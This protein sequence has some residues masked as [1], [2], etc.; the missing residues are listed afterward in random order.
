MMTLLSSSV[1]EPWSSVRARWLKAAGVADPAKLNVASDLI[2]QSILD[3]V[4]RGNVLP[5]KWREVPIVVGDVTAWISVSRDA[6]RVGVPGDSVRVSVTALTA[7]HVADM[8]GVLLATPKIDDAAWAAADVRLEPVFVQDSQQRARFD[9]AAM[10][11]HSTTIDHRMATAGAGEGDLVRGVGKGWDMSKLIGPGNAVNYGF[12]T[13]KPTGAGGRAPWPAA[14]KLGARVW[15]PPGNKH[16]RKHADYSQTLTLVERA[17]RIEGPS[18][19]SAADVVAL[20]SDASTAA[21]VSHEGPV[22]MRDPWIEPCAPLDAG[23]GC[24]DVGTGGPPPVLPTG[25]GGGL[26]A[27]LRRVLPIGVAG[28]VVG[29]A[30][31]WDAGLWP[32]LR[33]HT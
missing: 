17:A 14:T 26:G 1:F 12:P 5:I 13:S 32:F 11:I 21:L 22:P 20:A 18:G 8:L 23:G 15:Q 7:Q 29:A 33:R 9:L 4:R 27:F 10:E 3:E 6:L 31:A 24:P 2:Q 30:I 16:N 19:E 25:G 28:L